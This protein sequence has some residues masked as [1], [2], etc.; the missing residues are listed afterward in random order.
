MVAVVVDHN[1]AAAEVDPLTDGRVADIGQMG[2][3]GAVADRG[4]LQLN[5]VADAA[6][7]PHHALRADIG[8][9]ADR[10]LFAHLGL[11]NLRVVDR[12]A[13][14]DLRLFEDGVRADD[15]S[16]ADLAARTDV[17]PRQDGCARRNIRVRR[18]IGVRRVKDLHAL[19]NQAEVDPLDHGKLRDIGRTAVADLDDFVGD[20]NALLRARSNRRRD[21]RVQRIR[22]G[23]QRLHQHVP[24]EHGSEDMRIARD[25]LALLV[26]A[27]LLGSEHTHTV[28]GVHMRLRQMG[29]GVR[30]GQRD[31]RSDDQCMRALTQVFQRGK[32]V[33][34]VERKALDA[35]NGRLPVVVHKAARV[36]RIG[37][38]AAHRIARRAEQHRTR[39]GGEAAFVKQAANQGGSNMIHAENPSVPQGQKSPHFHYRFIIHQAYVNCISIFR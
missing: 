5:K 10:Y 33:C 26:K 31:R 4:L 20:R 13:R 19:F 36:H 15:R 16:R 17:T 21:Q 3:L 2:Y 29:E 25:G 1:R 22:A 18:D 37:Q 23:L 39:P 14:A 24:G 32:A 38:Q 27:L 9:R 28:A 30:L 34:R 8:E 11:I 35:C 6:A 12:G 7:V